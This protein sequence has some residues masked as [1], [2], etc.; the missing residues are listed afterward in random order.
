MTD[1]LRESEQTFGGDISER[2]H[3]AK[4]H[5]SYSAEAICSI[6]VGMYQP[7]PLSET[8][9]CDRAEQELLRYLREDPLPIQDT[10]D[11]GSH[12]KNH[13]PIVWWKENGGRFATLAKLARKYLCIPATS[14]PSERLFSTAGC[15]VTARRACLDPDNVNILC[16][17]KSNLH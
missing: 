14:V 13:N 6:L 11:S 3:P 4:K 10:D 15:V 7:Q 5:Q 17:L 12:Q 1:I 16:F 9:P 2:N 8:L